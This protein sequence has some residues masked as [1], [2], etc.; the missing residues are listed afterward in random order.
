[1]V[2]CLY[3]DTMHVCEGTGG[4]QRSSGRVPSLSPR[5]GR[6][7]WPALL[8]A[9]TRGGCLASW[10]FTAPSRVSPALSYLVV[11]QATVSLRVALVSVSRGF[12]LH[13]RPP[14]L[15]FPGEK[16]PLATPASLPAC[17][18]ELCPTPAPEMQARG[19]TRAE[20]LVQEW[21]VERTERVFKT[22]QEV[23]RQPTGWEN[24]F[25]SH[26]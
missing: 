7:A 19:P 5:R 21:G 3:A 4:G 1:M 26:T 9:M 10:V 17:G 20:A 15:V 8:T 25:T 2:T 16:Q 22:Y 14:S 18:R 24:T 23:K 12:S 11:P 6:W 13:P